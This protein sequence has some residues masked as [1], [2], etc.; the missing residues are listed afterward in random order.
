MMMMMRKLHHDMMGG[1][2]LCAEEVEP[3]WKEEF[4]SLL[5]VGG[6]G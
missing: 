5:G 6:I 3:K 1:E 4:Y 2:V